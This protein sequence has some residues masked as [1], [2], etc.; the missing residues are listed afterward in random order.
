[1]SSLYKL[2]KDL[3]RD[4]EREKTERESRGVNIERE[5]ERRHSPGRGWKGGGS[6]TGKREN[7]L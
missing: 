4:P 7:H 6:V 1:M 3:A 2:R 5:G